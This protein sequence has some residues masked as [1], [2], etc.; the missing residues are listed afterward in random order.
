[1]FLP[2][3]ARVLAY[4]LSIGF[5][6]GAARAAAPANDPGREIL[7]VND[8]WGALPTTSLP[9]GTTGGASAAASRTV[10]VT[11]RKELVA[12]LAYPDP[13]PKLVYIKGVIDVNVDDAGHPLSCKDYARA[14]P[15]T[16]E[17]YSVHA[18]LTMYDPEGPNG[19]N[20]P[21]GGQEEARAASA[22]AQAARVR[23]RIPPNTT[24]Y[25]VG[26]DATLIGAWL[27]IRGDSG[28]QPMNVIV[29]NIG[30]QDT[31]DC[32]PEWSPNDGFTGNWNAQYDTISVSQAT[33]V[34]IDHN[35]FA[36]LRTRDDTQPLYF[37]H[38]HQ[39]HDG[40]VDITDESDLV[41]VSW[42]QFTSH[43]K[44]MLIGNSD[45]AAEDR[46]R[47]R[48]TVHHNLFDGVGQRAPRVRYGKVHVYNNVYRA[49]RNTNYRSSWGAG[50]ESQIYAENNYFDMSAS[51]GPM[52]VIDGKKG[53]R[54]TVVGNCW[55]SKDGCPLTDL[56]AIYNARFDPDLQSDAGWTPSL[57]GAAK[58]AASAEAARERVLQ[59]SGPGKS[60]VRE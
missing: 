20:V 52:E 8:G 39:V 4:V 7:T 57:Y 33:H 49:D 6:L 46:E 1:M 37:G 28:S 10:T 5:L 59:E 3:L 36:D 47:L 24:L 18:F 23:I 12:A 26:A 30:F 34:W 48:V 55:R 17:M 19:R 54:I 25:G 45:S 22:A 56:L 32:F 29:R 31:A 21:V 13:V 50:T 53:T 42:N 44:T 43:D 15:A 38:R 60:M 2:C 9:Q 41:T 14:D 16:G 40:F 58:S 51:F 35:R 11:N 27:D